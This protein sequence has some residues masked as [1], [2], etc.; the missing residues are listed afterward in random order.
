MEMNKGGVGGGGG[1]GIGLSDHLAVQA[2]RH[3]S[4]RVVAIE[5]EI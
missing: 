4:I 3:P 2:L 1:F 5:C